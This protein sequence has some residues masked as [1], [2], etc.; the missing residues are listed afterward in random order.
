MTTPTESEIECVARAICL[1]TNIAGEGIE[2]AVFDNPDAIY[3]AWI[4]GSGHVEP[5]PHWHRY[6]EQARAAIIALDAHRSEVRVESL[7]RAG[8]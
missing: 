4:K 1:Q 7:G 2:H 8:S 3:K 6:I 5:H